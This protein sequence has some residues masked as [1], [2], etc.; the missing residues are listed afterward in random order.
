MIQL[1][2][3]DPTPIEDSLR[4]AGIRAAIARV[5]FA[6]ALDAALAHET[7]DVAIYDPSTP[8]LSRRIVEECIRRSGRELP[9]VMLED[10]VAVGAQVL[11][12]IG[13]R[14]N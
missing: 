4:A 10:P 14:R 1:W 7:F 3:T 11:R 9:I 5:D 12:V 8:G 6:A 13:P 2:T